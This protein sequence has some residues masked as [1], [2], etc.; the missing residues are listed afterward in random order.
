MDISY[1][2]GCLANLGKVV[3]AL[4]N[5]KIYDNIFEA[6]QEGWYSMDRG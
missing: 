2:G 1:I 6:S 4:Y 3:I 5:F